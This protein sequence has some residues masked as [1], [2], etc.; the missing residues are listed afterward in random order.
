MLVRVLATTVSRWDVKIRSGEVRGGLPGR[1]AIPLPMQ[2]GRDA[3]GVVEAVG[4]H[5]QRFRPGNRVAG[6]VHP[7]NPHSPLTLRGLGNLSTDIDYP[8]HTMPGGNAQFVVRPESYWLPLPD[9][10][11]PANAAAALWSYATAHRVLMD[12]LGARLGDTILVVGASGGMGSAT[13]DLARCMGVRVTA[14]TRSAAKVGFLSTQGAT[15]VVVLHETDAA[16]SIR[17]TA[18]PLGLDGAIDY[19]GDPAMLR[20]CIDVLRPGGTLVVLAGEG[21]AAPLPV[22]A[23]DC[24]WL[25]L[26]IRGARAST[27]SDQHAVLTLLAQ[28]RITPAIGATLPMSEVAWAHRML[29]AGEVLGRVVLDPWG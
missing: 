5:V 13:L 14:V 9:S 26:N 7:A 18:G 19:S 15:D 28:Q 20:L 22:T 23:A 21:S 8:G 1:R 3:V 16:A 6:L 11:T 25:E 2:P 24:I 17:G 29:E 12:R 4:E 10:V 27:L